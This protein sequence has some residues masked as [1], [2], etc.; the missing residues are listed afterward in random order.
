[1]PAGQLLDELI[2][3]ALERPL[4]EPGRGGQRERAVS[5][6]TQGR[7]A[8]ESEGLVEQAQGW[9]AAD[10]GRLGQRVFEPAEVEPAARDGETVTP[11]QRGQILAGRAE[12]PAEPGNLGAQRGAGIGG[13]VRSP[14]LVDDPNGRDRPVGVHQEHG[15]QQALPDAGQRHGTAVD[16]YLDR[17]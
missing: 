6:L 11:F 8:V 9:F 14:Q 4:G 15:Q 5:E 17:A 7:A 16:P 2:I 3:E 12:R 1:V 13:Q 10:P